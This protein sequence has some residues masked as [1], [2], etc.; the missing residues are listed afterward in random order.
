[1]M[2]KD[3]A[4]TAMGSSKEFNVIMSTIERLDWKLR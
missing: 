3:D 1:M 4:S 2:K